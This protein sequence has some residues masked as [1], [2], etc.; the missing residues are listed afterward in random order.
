[1]IYEEIPYSQV[2]ASAKLFLDIEN[3]TDYDPFLLLMADEAMRHISDLSMFELRTEVVPVEDGTA[4][5][6]CGFI[7]FMGAWFQNEQ[8]VCVGLPYLETKVIS[9]CNCDTSTCSGFISTSVQIN[10]NHL[11]FRNPD[12][13][14]ATTASV[15]FLGMRID[16]NGQPVMKLSHE[17][18]VRA[19]M[20]WRFCE[21]VGPTHDNLAR[22]QMLMGKGANA[23]A[24][25]NNQ[26][27]YLQASANVTKWQN[28]KQAIGRVFT[29]WIGA[30]NSIVL[31]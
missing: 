16:E 5:L 4:P 7:R 3:T 28:N 12:A 30:Y 6:P 20:V 24:E 11:V 13:M 17:R 14:T 10:G 22:A 25:Y 19:Y 1:M 21:K 9:Y 2:I 18:A 15:A 26:K 23:R 31:R 29:A 27:K 8:G